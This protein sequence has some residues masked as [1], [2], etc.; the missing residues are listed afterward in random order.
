MRKGKTMSYQI[1]VASNH[2]KQEVPL[3][4]AA[5]DRVS[6]TIVSAST[7]QVVT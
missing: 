1:T 5:A 2:F 7:G 6:V 4:V 3:T